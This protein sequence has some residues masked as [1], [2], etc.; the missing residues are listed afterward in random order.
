MKR[1]Q[2]T[3]TEHTKSGESDIRHK[4]II[5]NTKKEEILGH[6]P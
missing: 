3:K 2:P 4:V 5:A 6:L 1:L